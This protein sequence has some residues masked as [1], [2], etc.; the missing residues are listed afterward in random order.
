MFV[1]LVLI[2]G[3]ELTKYRAF[4]CFACYVVKFGRKR[5]RESKD[6]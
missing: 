6:E 2:T 5:R 4:T 1:A 3:L